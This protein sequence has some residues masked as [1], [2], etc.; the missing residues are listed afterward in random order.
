ME[1]RENASRLR[2]L[3]EILCAM[4]GKGGALILKRVVALWREEVVKA[5]VRAR[6][7]RKIVIRWSNLAGQRA[8]DRWSEYARYRAWLKSNECAIAR[9]RDRRVCARCFARYVFVCFV[10]V[11]VCVFAFLEV[12]IGRD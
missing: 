5:R 2:Y 3:R 1:W 11:C 10:C 4:A 6:A 9:A 12:G 7:S 8:L